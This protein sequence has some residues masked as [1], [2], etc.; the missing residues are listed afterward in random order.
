[1]HQMARR[2]TG[3]P[4]AFPAGRGNA[5]V[6]AAGKLQG[7]KGTALPGA[8][9]EPGVILARRFG[10]HTGHNLDA[11]RPQHGKAFSRNPWVQILH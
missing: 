1:M 5:T 3:D 4:A 6:K 11:R 10:H 9:K 7:H 2:R 8:Q